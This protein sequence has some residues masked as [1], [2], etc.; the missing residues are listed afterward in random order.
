MKLW[1]SNSRTI[2]LNSH[3]GAAAMN[4]CHWE[5]QVRPEVQRDRDVNLRIRV[6]RAPSRLLEHTR[7]QLLVRNLKVHRRHYKKR[8]MLSTLRYLISYLVL[9]ILMTPSDLIRV[10]SSTYSC[11][12]RFNVNL[13]S[14]CWSNCPLRFPVSLCMLHNFIALLFALLHC[15]W[16][17]SGSIRAPDSEYIY[18]YF[19]IFSVPQGTWR[20][21]TLK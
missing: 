17:N 7:I 16:E 2:R 21:Y 4:G 5:R 15:I 13:P 9:Q 18:C 8:L 10:T 11:N 6:T 19:V 1:A 20:Y 12:A 3:K 14:M